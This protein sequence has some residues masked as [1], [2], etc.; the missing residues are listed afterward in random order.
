[1]NYERTPHTIKVYVGSI[2][3][4]THITCPAV[5]IFMTKYVI[6][7]LEKRNAALSV[8]YFEVLNIYGEVILKNK[9]TDVV[10]DYILRQQSPTPEG[11]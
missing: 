8:R 1:M 5:P 4:Y 11:W 10:I 2:L 9:S 7:E 6:P 3:P